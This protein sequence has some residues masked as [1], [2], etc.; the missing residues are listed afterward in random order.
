MTSCLLTKPEVKRDL[1]YDHTSL[2]KGGLCIQ[3]HPQTHT[4][5][6]SKLLLNHPM[7]LYCCLYTVA[8]SDWPTVF[9]IVCWQS[10]ELFFPSSE[11]VPWLSPWWQLSWNSSRQ[12]SSLKLLTETHSHE[13]VYTHP[14]LW[15]HLRSNHKKCSPSWK[16]HPSTILT[17]AII[18]VVAVACSHWQLALLCAKN[19][20]ASY[21]SYKML[22]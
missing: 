20:Q 17:T 18:K 7:Y 5:D 3:S 8:Y 13:L 22:L 4:L 10:S 11:A 6:A 2:W 1:D 21:L 12:F 9:A 16:Q 14:S 15:S 19:K